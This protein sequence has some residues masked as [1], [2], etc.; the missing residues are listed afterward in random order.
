MMSEPIGNHNRGGGATG[1]TQDSNSNS[2]KIIALVE[3]A[4]KM[5]AIETAILLAEQLGTASQAS[6][7]EIVLLARTYLLSSEP[8]RCIS[9]LEQRDLLSVQS[10][11]LVITYLINICGSND[12]KY[13]D[14]SES[15][16]RING[17]I[18]AGQALLLLN[19]CEDCLNLLNS[20]IK[21]IEETVGDIKIWS[22]NIAN[23]TQIHPLAIM[24]C[25]LGKCMDAIENRSD[26]IRHLKTSVIIDSSCIDAAEYLINKGLLNTN[27][28]RSLFE[29]IPFPPCRKVFES[30]YRT[31]LLNEFVIPSYQNTES[32]FVRTPENLASKLEANVGVTSNPADQID[33]RPGPLLVRQAEYYYNKQRSDEAYKLA[34]KAYHMDPFDKRCLV[35]YIATLVDLGFKNELFYLGHE[36]SFSNPK[37]EISW[38][39]VGCYYYA[40]GKYEMAHKHLAKSTKI[41]KRFVY[42]WIALG[43][44]FSAQ[45]ES[46]HAVTVYRTAMRSAPGDFRPMLLLAKELSRGN[47]FSM[48]LQILS[49][50]VRMEP[51]DPVILNEIGVI[52]LK[53]DRNKEACSYLDAA[54]SLL[55]S[56][57]GPVS[58]SLHET[59]QDQLFEN[60]LFKFSNK[61]LPSKHCALE[62]LN[63]YAISLRRLKNY[64]KALECFSL[65]LSLNPLDP[66]I[67]LSIGFTYHLD[68]KFDEAITYYHKSLALRANSS[69]CVEMLHRAITDKGHDYASD[70]SVEFEVSSKAGMSS[71]NESGGGNAYYNKYS[72]NGSSDNISYGDI[73]LSNEM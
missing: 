44:V 38:Y 49:N 37:S 18:I 14:V 7:Q 31:L 13:L 58:S 53:M 32:S 46:E 12:K 27:D 26:A 56:K 60:D 72:S 17:V 45:D 41:N 55:I 34:V 50:C 63:N 10:L 67:H 69:F 48:A 22:K 29:L 64:Y 15:E 35:I 39:A 21:P 28:K 25:I 11:D 71:K 68:R 47:N 36:L 9:L 42:S 24:N 19:K 6:S 23:M 20:V 54:S 70:S 59:S 30:L 4:I 3:N 16:S 61:L 51:G 73:S 52:L 57:S 5:G 8:R 33:N 1:S 43:N 65:C 2:V 66:D 40:C 62:I